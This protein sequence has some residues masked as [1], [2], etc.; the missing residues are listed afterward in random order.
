M[1]IRTRV[2]EFLTQAIRVLART[3][4]PRRG[5]RHRRAIIESLEPRTLLT[6]YSVTNLNDAGAGSLRDAISLA[7]ANS[8]ADKIMFATSGTI[9]LTTGQMVVTD[10]LTI[11][12]NGA[13]NTIVDAQQLTRICEVTDTAGHVTW[14]D[15]TFKNG[16]TRGN[17]S[18][19]IRCQR[20]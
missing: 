9:A 5:I 13:A 8:G 20:R 7:N 19:E 12:G 10:S 14:N 4:R 18:F 3:H 15:T 16:L 2:R 6:A 11:T 1:A 17:R